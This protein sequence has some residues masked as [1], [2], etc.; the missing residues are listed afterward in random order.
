MRRRHSQWIE[1]KL[2]RDFESE[3]TDAHRLSTASDGSVE[4]FGRDIL[5]SY[6]STATRQ[7]LT[8][9]FSTWNEK[10]NLEFNRIFARFLPK[11]SEAREKPY[12]LLGR[13]SQELRTIVTERKLKF[14]IDFGAGYSV[15][16]FLD[17]R[18]NRS[19]IRKIAPR[20]LLNC[21]SYTCSFSVAAAAAGAETVNVDLSRKSLAR[22]RGNFV[23][24]GLAPERHRF[25]ADDARIVLQRMA[26]RAEKFDLIII[27]PPTFARARHGK[28]FRIATDFEN[29]LRAA[30]QIAMA[31]A[32]ILLSSNCAGLGEE[33]LE[34]MAGRCLKMFERDGSFHRQPRAADFPPATGASTIW[35][36]L[37]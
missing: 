2:L 6:Q 5:I 37:R 27:D 19:Y 36:S 3:G 10:A 1:P 15:G 11:Q 33:A 28:P 7:R 22:G 23:L 8:A 31:E 12:L 34:D 4:R 9:E 17:Q 16:L 26:R 24:N 13:A 29:L 21:F 14:G 18:E 35:L 25:I 30:F 32:R 20:R